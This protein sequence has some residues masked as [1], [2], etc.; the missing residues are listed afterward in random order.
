[1]S[2]ISSVD[3]DKSLSD[4]INS[5]ID[6]DS[7]IEK[8][9]I[10]EIFFAN[11][12]RQFRYYKMIDK[13]FRKCDQNLIDKMWNTLPILRPD[14]EYVLNKV[15]IIYDDTLTKKKQSKCNVM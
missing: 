9:F 15:N 8:N 3:T 7:T 5:T 10:P 13:Y 1:M 2:D 6:D 4:N 11:N 12:Q 14:I